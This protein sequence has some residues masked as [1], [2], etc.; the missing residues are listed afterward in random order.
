[1][2]TDNTNNSL[3][4]TVSHL[5]K[6]FYAYYTYIYLVTAYNI[7]K[8]SKMAPRIWWFMATLWGGASYAILTQTPGM[9]NPDSFQTLWF[10]CS[11][12][13]AMFALAGAF[14]SL[15]KREM[16]QVA[17]RVIM[18]MLPP[19]LLHVIIFAA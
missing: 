10:L 8:V 19:L 5:S 9:E 14:S 17:D 16:K 18:S 12:I 2:K 11:L 6:R 7:R 4:L 1:M 15:V 3:S 13:W